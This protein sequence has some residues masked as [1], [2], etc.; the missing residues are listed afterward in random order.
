MLAVIDS[1]VA[2][3]KAILSGRTMKQPEVM[4]E[5]LKDFMT[6]WKDLP[7]SADPSEEQLSA[8]AQGMVELATASAWQVSPY[9]EAAP[10]E[11]LLYELA[12]S[13]IDGPSLYLVSDGTSVVSPPHEHQTWAVIAG[14]RGR[15]T[16]RRYAIQS[17]ERRVVLE[18][19]VV[20]LGAG[21]VLVLRTHEI[22][23]TEVCSSE[24][25]F[26][27]HLYGRPLHALPAFES[28]RYTVAGGASSSRHAYGGPPE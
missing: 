19:S 6:Q 5:V 13:P 9:R 20:E 25:T 14:I 4:R 18:S 27:L 8:L 3:C 11:E 24:A 17:R 22:H 2:I 16:N 21:E 23:A 15:E 26:H 28:R 7:R 12:V 10:G 1:F